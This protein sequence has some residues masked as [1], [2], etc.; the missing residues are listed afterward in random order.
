MG[1]V[2]AKMCHQETVLKKCALYE[3]NVHV[4]EAYRAGLKDEIWQSYLSGVA[5]EFSRT[6]KIYTYSYLVS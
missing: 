3:G 1:D 6:L 2:R 4:I 5:L